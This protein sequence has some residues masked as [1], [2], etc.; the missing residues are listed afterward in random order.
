MVRIMEYLAT[1]SAHIFF[2]TWIVRRERVHS[3]SL[4]SYMCLIFVE[5]SFIQCAEGKAAHCQYEGQVVVLLGWE[6]GTKQ[7]GR[8]VSPP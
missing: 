5:Q 7:G 8:S 2:G 6:K 3:V 1:Y 4:K